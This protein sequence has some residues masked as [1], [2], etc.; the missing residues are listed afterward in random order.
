MRKS[1][2]VTKI[3]ALA[4]MIT[5]SSSMMVNAAPDSSSEEESLAVTNNKTQPFTEE[6]EPEDIS[7]LEA[8]VMDREYTD[9]DFSISEA[10]AAALFNDESNADVLFSTEASVDAQSSAETNE[11]QVSSDEL[12][13]SSN[14][15][16][17]NAYIVT[18]DNIINETITAAGE[19]RWYA[20]ALNE[21]SK[22]TIN[23]QMVAALDADLYMYSLNKETYQ[24]ELIGGSATA[25]VGVSEYYNNT[26]D[27]G[28]YFFAVGGYEGSGNFAFAYFQ[29]TADVGNEPNDSIATATNIS[30]D[31]NVSGVI[32]NPSDVDFYTFTITNPVVMSYSISTSDN[33]KLAY[34]TQSG[35][36]AAAY[37]IDDLLE[38]MPGTYYF[39]V[40]SPNGNY[41]ATSTYTLNFKKISDLANDT[42]ANLLGVSVKAGI[43]FQSNSTG[44]KCYVNGNPIDISYSYDKQLS[45]SAG[46]QSYK[47]TIED[48]DDVVANLQEGVFEPSAVHYLNSTRPNLNVG[49]KPVL[50]LTFTSSTDFYKIHCTCSGAYK[51]NSL[52][53]DLKYVTVLI[54]P[55]TGK[56]VDISDFNYFYDFAPVGSNS[57]TFTRPYTMIYNYTS[58]N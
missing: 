43:V 5:L 46:S 7:S 9:G 22:I 2:I 38:L 57:L 54:D 33:Y 11:T 17:N 23:L 41:S 27:A 18:N 58:T 40:Y 32:D 52:W 48:R 55:D 34:A 51:E 30:F 21:K 6:L 28:T 26:L 16:P 24:L 53:Q 1:K 42:S 14:T 15:S 49:S 13:D 39:G 3:L 35:T 10:T 12:A 25:G 56:L 44:S 8:N 31:T 20:F 37:S 50:E 47:I 36:S 4:L 29:S 45:N 19:M